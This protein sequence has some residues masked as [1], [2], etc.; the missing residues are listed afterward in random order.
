MFNTGAK[1]R[2]NLTIIYSLIKKTIIN[3][4]NWL[5]CVLTHDDESHYSFVETTSAEPRK[6][7]Y[8]GDLLRQQKAFRVPV[9]P[10]FQL[11][12][13]NIVPFFILHN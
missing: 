1:L 10:V 4:N 5:V 3:R 6:H 12:S 11:I 7:V 9:V 2:K 13:R 8:A